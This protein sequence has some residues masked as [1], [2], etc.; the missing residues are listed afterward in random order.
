MGRARSGARCVDSILVVNKMRVAI[1]Y[2]LM[3]IVLLPFSVVIF[4]VAVTASRSSVFS[5]FLLLSVVIAIAVP[6]TRGIIMAVARPIVVAFAMAIAFG[7]AVVFAV[8]VAS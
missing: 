8:V 3:R 4:N 7:I 2:L 6:T 1:G 5:S